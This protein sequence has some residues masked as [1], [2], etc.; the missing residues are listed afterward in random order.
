M[1]ASVSPSSENEE[2]ISV[3]SLPSARDIVT[4]P[5]CFIYIAAPSEFV[6][7]TPSR[8]SVTSSSSPASIVSRPSEIVPATRYFPALSIVVL[9]L[10]VSFSASAVSTVT[11]VVSLIFSVVSEPDVP[12]LLCP[13]EQDARSIAEIISTDISFLYFLLKLIAAFLLFHNRDL[14]VAVAAS[15]VVYKALFVALVL[16]LHHVAELEEAAHV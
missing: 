12:E 4:F 15:E 9:S 14:E 2:D 10:R 6:I 3:F 16:Q 7:E 5:T 1:T 11:G 8:M 13:P